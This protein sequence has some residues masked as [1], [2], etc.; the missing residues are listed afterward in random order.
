MK[1]KITV[2]LMVLGLVGILS[3]FAACNDGGGGGGGGGIEIPTSYTGNTAQAEI[4]AN[5]AVDIVRHLDAYGFN[6]EPVDVVKSI[7]DPIDIPS[8]RV[9]STCGGYYELESHLAESAGTFNGN[10]SFVDYCNY[11]QSSDSY[12][13][14]NGATPFE[15]MFTEVG[16]ATTRNVYLTLDDLIYRTANSSIEFI[17]GTEIYDYYNDWMNEIREFYLDY[18]LYDKNKQNKTYWADN[19]EKIINLIPFVGPNEFTF[20]GRFYD[21]DYGF[22][23]IETDGTITEN[24][25]ASTITGVM[26]IVGLGSRARLTFNAD[27]SNLL[28]VDADN[29]GAFDDGSFAN[30]PWHFW[31]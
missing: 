24:R 13:Y 31:N 8:L 1:R 12:S 21:H 2:L 15:G 11:W 17:N 28:E 22:V 30:V 29:D 14:L 6:M 3:I 19:T 26:Y 9:D 18:V 4:T 20:V 23:D 27:G 10:V 7:I 5:N 16:T 25:I